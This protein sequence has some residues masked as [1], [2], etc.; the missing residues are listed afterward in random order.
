MRRNAINMQ[1]QWKEGSDMERMI[2][3]GT[4]AAAL[5][6]KSADVDVVSAYPI[7]PQTNII[8]S[9][10]A[11]VNN[12]EMNCRFIMVE[13]EHSAMAATVAASAAGSRAFT[14]TSSQ[15]L[16]YMHEVLHMAS[17]G[18]LP[19][20]LV[21]VNR[22]VFAPWT[23]WSDHQ[24]SLSQRDTGWLQ[25]YCSSNQEIYNTIIQ[26]FK[27]AETAS[28]PVMVNFDGFFLSH[29]STQLTVP[30]Q[31]V[32]Q[33]FLPKQQPNWS[34]DVEHPSTF[35][36]VT[37]S[38]EYAEYREMLSKDIQSAI[39]IVKQSADEYERL[40]GMY[41]GGSI[42][43]GYTS[44]AEIVVIAMG[45]MASEMKYAVQRLRENG[46]KVG[47]IRIRIFTPFPMED[48]LEQIQKNEKVIVFD[49]NYN[50]GSNGG[51]LAEKLRSTLYQQR[52]NVEVNNVVAGIG[53]M[54]LDY[55]AIENII[56][57][58]KDGKRYGN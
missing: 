17:G 50:F 25:Y 44:D 6:V 34:L 38:K 2:A 51:I 9:I 12:K 11:M 42:E 31:D 39:H 27:V 21:N 46:V 10:A 55:R 48:I 33:Q 52:E 4:L 43:S 23:L 18:R 22:G 28:L 7:T 45:S 24:D 19:V 40:T 29:C 56:L 16:L 20:V 5:A 57:E 36:S 47:F 30:S 35:G 3:T 14:A 53:G 41:D 26:A 37:N 49:R 1:L 8:E 58:V 13:G 32:I 54:D 15:G